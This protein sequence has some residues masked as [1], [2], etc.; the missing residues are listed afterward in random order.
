[1]NNQDKNR[2]PIKARETHWATTCSRWLQKRGA[3]PNGIS[4]FSI[5]FAAFAGIALFFAFSDTHYLIR[6]SLFIVGALMIQCRLICNLLDGMVAVEGG[7]KSPVGA[8]YNELPDRIADTLIIIGVGYGLSSHFPIAIT[9]GW[10]GA[11]FAV[12]TA[13]VRVLGGSCGLEQ[14]FTGPMAKQHRMALLTFIA[15]IAAF[16]P[17]LWGAWLFLIALWIIIAGAALTTIFRTRQIL[18]DLS[19]GV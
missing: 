1:M 19:Q 8:V 2:R 15:I 12:M 6:S 14:R 4:M 17:V 5:L 11:F 9:L 13:Y 10:V 16:T 18:R 3:T 7:M